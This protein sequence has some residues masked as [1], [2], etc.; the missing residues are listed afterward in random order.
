M[1]KNK[2]IGVVAPLLCLVIHTPAISRTSDV[3]VIGSRENEAQL[4]GSGQYISRERLTTE[5]TADIM[6]VLRKEVPGASIYGEDG[7]GL[8]PN[9]SFRGVNSGRSSKIT[10]MEDGVLSA[11]APYSAP[12]AYY[13]PYMA[14]MSGLEALKGSSQVLYGP[15][16]TGG[17]LNFISTPLRSSAQTHYSL[18]A[19]Q[20]RELQVQ[21]NH[22]DRVGNFSYVVELAGRQVDGFD[23]I[24]PSAVEVYDSE[25]T[26]HKIYEPMIK[27]AYDIDGRFF[28]RFELKLGMTNMTAF[29]SYLG[30]SDEDFK[31][32]P[33]R[34]Y[35]GARFDRIDTEQKRSYFRH[36]LGISDD[37][38]L[39]STVYYN[40]FHRNWYKLNDVKVGTGSFSSPNPNNANQRGVLL[41]SA[42]GELRVRANNRIY[43][44]AGVEQTLDARLGNHRFKA[45]WRVHQDSERRKQWQD[46]F[47]QDTTGL[48]T[49]IN[50]GIEGTQANAK[51]DARAI[52]LYVQDEM[53]FGRLSVTPG[54]RFETVKFGSDNFNNL[55]PRATGSIKTYN[56]GVGLRYQWSDEIVLFGGVHRGSALPGPSAVTATT[57]PITKPETSL[58]FETGLRAQ[59][60]RAM[61]FES[62]LFYTSLRDMLA[63]ESIAIGQTTTSAIGKATTYGIEFKG[64]YDL[65]ESLGRSWSNP[66]YLTAT[67][68]KAEIGGDYTNSGYLTGKKGNNLPY[69]P[70]LTFTVGSGFGIGKFFLD[71]NGNYN[72]KMYKTG[73]NLEADKVA[74]FFTLDSTISYQ[75]KPETKLIISAMNVLD[76]EYMISRSPYGARAGRP[77]T[78][79]VGLQGQF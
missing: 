31:A 67:Y 24:I 30:L 53:T 64:A 58:S 47:T 12:A 18:F 38:Q 54:M 34:R 14:R 40:K 55:N 71:V 36:Y 50:R 26:G 23:K 7:Y 4:T 60:S 70:E 8:F 75:L 66:Y 16:T 59:P 1:N 76:K 61:R 78:F 39:T 3:L 77:Q 9:I 52:A 17:V 68:N 37:T 35:P 21:L 20:D 46:V 43:E 28:Q 25:N 6:H 44:A 15:S 73:E 2:I 42:A 41:G 57:N 69:A 10:I 27:L 13:S 48:V 49:G 79:L 62:T 5:G 29:E 33:Y 22:G 56:P 72:G 19:G 74:S 45:G 11:P 32:D 63:L 51:V 65:G